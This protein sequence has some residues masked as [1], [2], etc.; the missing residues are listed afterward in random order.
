[1]A[2]NYTIHNFL[3]NFNNIDIPKLSREQS[4]SLECLIT[5]NE[6]TE[7]DTSQNMKNDKSP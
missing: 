7:S 5:C 1:M 2:K 3:G 6:I 4:N